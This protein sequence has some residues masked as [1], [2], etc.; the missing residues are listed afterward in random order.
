M[1]TYLTPPPATGG[2]YQRQRQGVRPALDAVLLCESRRA[3]RRVHLM[4]AAIDLSDGDLGRALE[5]IAGR[6]CEERN[7]IAKLRLSLTVAALILTGEQLAE[8]STKRMLGEAIERAF[9]CGAAGPDM[10]G[11]EILTEVVTR[12]LGEDEDRAPAI[13]DEA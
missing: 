10:W 5:G 9:L 8:A 1:L 4:S 6:L 11:V 3:M 7:T 2:P 12:L 13:N